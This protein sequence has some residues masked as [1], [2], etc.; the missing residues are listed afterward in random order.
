LIEAAC[1]MLP[2]CCSSLIKERREK[3]KKEE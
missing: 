1:T 3:E 2:L